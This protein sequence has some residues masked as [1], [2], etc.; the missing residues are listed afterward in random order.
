VM[1][2]TAMQGGC[3][4]EN[5]TYLRVG[6]GNIELAGLFAPKPLAMSA[7]NDWTKEIET[8][9]LP[10]IKKLY[11]MLGAP[12]LV[13]GKHFNF[14]HNYNYV[15]RAMMYPWMNRHLKLGLPE[16]I[17]EQDYR[18]LTRTEMTV[19]DEK[20]PRPKAG[21]EAFEVKLLKEMDGASRRQLAALA[22]RDK[23]TLARYREI[24]GGAVDVMIGRSPAE[25]GPVQ[26]EKKSEQDR[27]KYIEITLLLKTKRH[28]ESL[29]AVFLM[30][31]EHRGE[32]VIWIDTAGKS[33]LF[34]SDGSPRPE[35]RALLD[36][37]R[38][39][40]G[41]DLLYQGE[42]LADGKPLAQSR[43]VGNTR[44]YAGYT[45]G[46]NHPLFCQ[47]VHDVMTV[48]GYCAGHE[49]KPKRI[50]LFGLAGA[51]KWVAAAA[52]QLGTS[53]D[54]VAVDTGGFR[55]ARLQDIRH[56]DL[57][58]GAVKYGDVP[59][60]LALAAPHRLWLAGEGNRVPQI[61]AAAY[62]A[63]GHPDAVTSY[64]G[65]KEASAAAAVTWLLAK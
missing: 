65:S 13:A 46:Y 18:P 10:E 41:V 14:G 59:A 31:K 22:P 26:D 7:A 2:S 27:G 23:K 35:V 39:V 63:A 34:G 37:G 30:P 12:D 48:V 16:P 11:A 20:H 57:L 52:A 32:V 4:C 60:L 40:V 43:K 17:V 21:D 49:K 29:P 1:V 38:A 25:I 33:G 6:T 53:V 58:P 62:R 19:W 9:G 55:F 24:V 50:H 5:C 54:R 15:S 3:T 47:R 56:V 45:L 42:F 51:G 36:A 64:S 61:T 44:E 8:K 28:G